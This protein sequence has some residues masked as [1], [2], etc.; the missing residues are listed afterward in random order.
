MFLKQ[1]QPTRWAQVGRSEVDEGVI[2]T[3]W[4]W[5]TTTMDDDEKCGGDDGR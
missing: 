1:L 2:H 5:M 4:W 3:R